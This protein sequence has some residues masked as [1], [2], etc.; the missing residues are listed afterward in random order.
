MIL[1][2][3]IIGISVIILSLINIFANLLPFSP[4]IT[5]LIIVGG[6]VIEFLLDGLFAYIVHLF[7]NKWFEV[8]NKFYN[9]SNGEKK[10]YEK[11]KI[12][13]WK[14]KVWELG[15]LGGFSKKNLQSTNNPEYFKQFIIESN[16]GVLTHIIGLLIG[17]ALILIYLPLSCFWSVSLPISIVNF[18]LNLPSL[19]ILRYNTPKLHTVYKRLQRTAER[20]SSLKLN[21][22]QNAEKQENIANNDAETAEKNANITKNEQK[23]TYL[24]ENKE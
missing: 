21:E 4:I 2:L 12:R 15:G 22:N 19:F 17:F 3:S 20:E 16:K 10:F 7:P 11:I 14:D 9:V 5:I 24:T 23:T 8:N 18:L 13:K 1:Y 6:V